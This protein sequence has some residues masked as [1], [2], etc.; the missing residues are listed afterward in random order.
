MVNNFKKFFLVFLFLSSINADAIENKIIFKINNEIITSY[1]IIKEIKY[2]KILNPNIQNLDDATILKIAKNSII[3]EK[4]K[5][6]EID[7]NNQNAKLNEKYL[8]KLL[9]NIYLKINFKS[10]N[11]FEEYLTT[12]NLNIELIKNKISIEALW[13]ELIYSVF[14]S[15]IKINKENLKK[16]ILLNKNKTVKSYDLLEIVFEV[17]EKN[18]LKTKYKN[19]KNDIDTKG[20][21]NAALIHSVSDTGKIGGELGWVEQKSLSKKIKKEIDFLNDGDYSKPIIIPGGALIL[22]LNATK[23]KKIN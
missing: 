17:S 18:E 8:D 4:I 2:L 5:K 23:K 12:N 10:I 14:S 21:A 16:D 15:K 7:K 1:D 13:N 6:I 9:E 3:R 20:F 22:K 19:I 11:E